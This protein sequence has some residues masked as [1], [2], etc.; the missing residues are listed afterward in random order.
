MLVDRDE[1]AGGTKLAD[2]DE[3][4]LV[5]NAGGPHETPVAS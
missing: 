5:P 2:F 1:V 4:R 3:A